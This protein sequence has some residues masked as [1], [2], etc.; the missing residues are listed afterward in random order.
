LIENL[1]KMAEKRKR[2]VEELEEHKNATSYLEN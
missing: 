1:M 2:I